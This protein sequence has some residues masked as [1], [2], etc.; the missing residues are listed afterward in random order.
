LND[1]DLSGLASIVDDPC[2]KMIGSVCPTIQTLRLKQ[3]LLLTDRALCFIADSLWLENVDI[4]GCHRIT[5]HGIEV[6]AEACTGLECLHMNKLQHVSVASVRYLEQ[7][8]KGLRLVECKD[9]PL[10]SLDVSKWNFHILL[11]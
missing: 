11:K 10:I 8:C 4:S 3:C 5:D 7:C 2:I 1:L 6:L 9:C